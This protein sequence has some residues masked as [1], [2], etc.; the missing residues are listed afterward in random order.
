MDGGVSFLQ[1]SEA[2]GSSCRSSNLSA[3]HIVGR[4]M[5]ENDDYPPL[6]AATFYAPWSKVLSNGVR[7]G[8]GSV[9]KALKASCSRMGTS[10]VELYSVQKSLLYPGGKRALADGLAEAMDLGYC[11]CVGV[12]NAGTG[13]MKSFARKLDRRGVSLTSNQVCT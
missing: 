6:V 11:N 5:E 13:A 3:E 7:F 9:I 4:C 1:T 2:Y 8:G 10:S 12:T